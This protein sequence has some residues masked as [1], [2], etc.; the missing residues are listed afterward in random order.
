MSRVTRLAVLAC[1]LFVPAAVSAQGSIVGTVRD[2]SGG[3]LPG[4]AIEVSSPVLIEG[5]RTAVTD[6]TGQYRVVDLR[7]GVYAVTFTLAGFATVRRADIEVMGSF[8]AT[9]NAE[10]RVGTVAETVTVTGTTPTVDVDHH[11][12]ADDQPR[13]RRQGAGG[14]HHYGYAALVGHHLQHRRRRRR[15]RQS[16]RQQPAH[17]GGTQNDQQMTV[18]ANGVLFNSLIG[19]A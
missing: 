9:V 14:P 16:E 11:A 8:T 17:T 18:G 2:S 13:R 5:V 19:S 6:A 12:S 1:V 3:V 4:A 10:M 7:P 15:A